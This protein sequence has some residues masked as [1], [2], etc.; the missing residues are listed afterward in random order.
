[1]LQFFRKMIKWIKSHN[2]IVN[3]VL[4]IVTFWV[5]RYWYFT[6]FG[7]YEDDLTIIPR[8]IQMNFSELFNFIFD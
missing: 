6:Q 5:A 3:C 7:L 8:A 4:L 2:L 1:M